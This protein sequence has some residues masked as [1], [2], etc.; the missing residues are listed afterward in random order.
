M[1]H[2]PNAITLGNLFCGCLAIFYIFYGDLVQ[3]A[4]LVGLAA[5]LD[6]FDGFAAR[7]LKASSPIG[8]DLDSLADMVSF[9]AVPGFMMFKMITFVTGTYYGNG[10]GAALKTGSSAWYPLAGFVII[11][12]SAVRLAKFNND[13]RQTEG[14]IG[15]P[16]PANAILICSLPLVFDFGQSYMSLTLMN[17]PFVTD[18]ANLAIAACLLSLL[19]VTEIPMFSLKFRSFSWVANQTR[20]IY[21]AGCITMLILLKTAAIPLTILLYIGANVVQNIFSKKET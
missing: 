12:F 15:L 14:F 17:A 20:Y 10:I 6:F 2:I 1:K 18:G 8:K 5:I 3:A 7:L 11:L 19:L 13:K 4:Y 21:L 16:T 9:G